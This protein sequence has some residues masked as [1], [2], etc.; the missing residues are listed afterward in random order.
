LLRFR[1]FE[2]EM[3]DYHWGCLNLPKFTLVVFWNREALD[4]GDPVFN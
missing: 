1:L 3:D 4:E 2:V